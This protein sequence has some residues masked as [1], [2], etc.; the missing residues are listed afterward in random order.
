M[1]GTISYDLSPL[2][3]YQRRLMNTELLLALSNTHLY[4]VSRRPR[5]TVHRQGQALGASILRTTTRES[6][7][8]GALQHSMSVVAQAEVLHDGAYWAGLV[9]GPRT[10]P[11]TPSR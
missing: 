1:A 9:D 11:G 5:T 7:S 2:H 4:V 3:T 8:D 6:L 10:G